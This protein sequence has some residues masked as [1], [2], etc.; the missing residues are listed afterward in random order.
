MLNEIMN[1]KNVLEFSFIDVE[2]L[3][4]IYSFLLSLNELGNIS[5]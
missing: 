4:N 1:K 5:D 3:L 2:F